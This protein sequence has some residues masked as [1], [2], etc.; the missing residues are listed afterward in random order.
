MLL[1][2]RGPGSYG[3]PLLFGI[4]ASPLGA[5]LSVLEAGVGILHTPFLMELTLCG[6]SQ[7]EVLCRRSVPKAS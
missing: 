5:L 4:L 7:E 3:W 6:L 2:L 1:R